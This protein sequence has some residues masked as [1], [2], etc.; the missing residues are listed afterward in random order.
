MVASNFPLRII[1]MGDL[2]TLSMGNGERRDEILR[3]T[4]IS[5]LLVRS[6]TQPLAQSALANLFIPYL[7]RI[8]IEFEYCIFHKICN[9]ISI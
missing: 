8:G 4:V 2:G 6:S 3:R 9:T 1:I 5:L 7:K